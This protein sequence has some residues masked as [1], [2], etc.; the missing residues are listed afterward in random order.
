[1]KN[2]RNESDYPTA[3]CP[4]AMFVIFV[5]RSLSGQPNW[6]DISEFILAKSLSRSGSEYFTTILFQGKNVTPLSAP[7]ATK[8]SPENVT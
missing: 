6:S 2:L 4:V 5:T 8:S 7:Y 3:S 1:M